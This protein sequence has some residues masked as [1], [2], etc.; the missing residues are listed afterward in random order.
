MT[1]SQGGAAMSL[2]CGGMYNDHSVANF[3]LSLAV[4][5]FWKSLN[6]SQSYLHKYAVLCC[7]VSHCVS[8]AVLNWTCWQ[9]VKATKHI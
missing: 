7:F 1:V 6:I 5:E 4:K 9:C 8:E 3:V 2:R